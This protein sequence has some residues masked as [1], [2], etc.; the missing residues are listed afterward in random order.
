MLLGSSALPPPPYVA[1]CERQPLD[2]GS[3][4]TEVLAGARRAEADRA[5]LLAMLSPAA[6]AASASAP[7]AL[8]AQDLSKP[9]PAALSRLDTAAPL[10]ATVQP[11]L[12]QASVDFIDPEERA[13][14]ADA[15]GPPA[16][17]PELWATLHR[18]NANVNRAIIEQ[19]DLQTYGVEDYWSTPLENGVR[20]GDCEDYVLEKQRALI[21]AGVPRRAL[22]IAIVTTRWGESHAV[23]LVATRGGE[24]VL[25]NLSPWITPWQETDYLWRQREVAGDPFNWVMIQDPQVMRALR[26]SL[27]QPKTDAAQ[28]LQIASAQ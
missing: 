19:T 16:M 2:C 3:D 25:D 18:V 5:A 13:R 4:A 15:G 26:A 21:A 12:L 1:F 10:E 14:E 20:Y 28:P 22:N 17:T 23:L 9:P 11:A 24:F 8:S 27:P 6:V 7:A